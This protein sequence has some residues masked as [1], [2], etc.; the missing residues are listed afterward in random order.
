[1]FLNKKIFRVYKHSFETNNKN[2]F[3]NLYL[4][5]KYIKNMIRKSVNRAYK[6]GTSIIIEGVNIIPGLMEFNCVTQ[7]LLW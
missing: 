5:S 7:K 2:K 1:M 4:Q 6:E 3:D